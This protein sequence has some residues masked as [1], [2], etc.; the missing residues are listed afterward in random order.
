[1]TGWKK[2]GKRTVF[3]I[4]SYRCDRFWVFPVN[5]LVTGFYRDVDNLKL[6]KNAQLSDEHLSNAHLS[7]FTPEKNAPR[8]DNGIFE[9]CQS[10]LR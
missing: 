8:Q 4:I 9:E 1:M 7:D 5:S 2:N 10:S 6:R 3:K